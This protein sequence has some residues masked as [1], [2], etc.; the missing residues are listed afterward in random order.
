[1]KRA[2][3]AAALT[4]LATLAYGAPALTNVGA[5]AVEY[6]GRCTGADQYISLPGTKVGSGDVPAVPFY[7]VG[8]DLA[9]L[10]DGD[11]NAYVVIGT[12]GEN[13]DYI[14]RKVI[15]RGSG[16][17]MLPAGYGRL[18]DPGRQRANIHWQCRKGSFH[19]VYATFYFVLAPPAAVA[20]TE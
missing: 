12:T 18:F 9:H 11:P 20:K 5:F 3:L 1:M 13:G 4:L 8:T 14:S 7:I 17:L 10:I 6:D 16:L 2:S 15:G 19:R